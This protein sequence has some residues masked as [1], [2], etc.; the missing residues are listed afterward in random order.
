[1]LKSEVLWFSQHDGIAVAFEQPSGGSATI[2]FRNAASFTHLGNRPNSIFKTSLLLL[3]KM[4]YAG[5]NTALQIPAEAWQGGVRMGS[6][7]T[8]GSAKICS[9]EGGL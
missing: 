9:G 6:R 8:S 1:M 3:V 5:M 4:G 7:R 2:Y